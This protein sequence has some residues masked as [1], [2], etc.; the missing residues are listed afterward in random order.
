MD[1]SKDGSSF[2]KVDLRLKARSILVEAIS[3]NKDLNDLIT[4]TKWK[5]VDRT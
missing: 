5:E 4:S 3:L 2:E 1:F